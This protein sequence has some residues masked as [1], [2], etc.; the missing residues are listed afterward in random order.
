MRIKRRFLTL[1]ELMI[2]LALSASLISSGLF[3]YRYVATLNNDLLIKEK[4]AFDERLI[5]LRLA[6]LFQSVEIQSNKSLFFTKGES[7]LTQ[8]QGLVLRVKNPPFDIPTFADSVIQFLFVDKEKKLTLAT[9]NFNRLHS[10]DLPHEMHLEVLMEGVEK[11][12]FQFLVQ[13]E[14]SSYPE[15]KSG[16]WIKEW[17]IGYESLPIA[18]KITLF[19][20][21][22]HEMVFFMTCERSS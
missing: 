21:S 9:W 19:R 6:K 1:L 14:Q 22:P 11:I 17:L 16:A 3:F 10:K 2:A 8:G 18:V 7:M 12:E 13:E 15:L 5:L 4:K 20:E